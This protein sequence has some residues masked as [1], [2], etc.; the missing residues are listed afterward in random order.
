LENLKLSILA[1]NK[2]KKISLLPGGGGGGRGG[3]AA[4][5]MYTHVSKCKNYKIKI[6][7]YNYKKK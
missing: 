7:K 1:R 2:F 6:F 4:Q 5:I 3:K